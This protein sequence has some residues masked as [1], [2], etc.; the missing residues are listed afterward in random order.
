M[1]FSGGKRRAAVLALVLVVAAL[2]GCS[3]SP[4]AP[5]A[6]P[7]LPGGHTWHPVARAHAAFAAPSSWS[8]LDA[9]RARALGTGSPEWDAMAEQAGI[10]PE[11]LDELF[12]QLDVYLVGAPADGF[13]PNIGVALLPLP[14]L[15]TDGQVN[16]EYAPLA[17]T[18]PT[19][20]RFGSPVG[21]AL[22]VSFT[23]DEPGAYAVRALYFAMD[24]GLLAVTVTTVDA[25]S[26]D[27]LAQTVTSTIHAT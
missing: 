6:T 8:A 23:S 21:D 13:A 24:P 17:S 22:K 9:E 19:I 18:P 12:D 27:V 10:E 20:E 3:A 7:S 11:D 26:A 25:G 14:A 1:V 16:L 5:K 4:S 15:P 2:A